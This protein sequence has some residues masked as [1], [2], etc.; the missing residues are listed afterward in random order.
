MQVKKNF[1]LAA[2]LAVCAAGGLM[3]CVDDGDNHVSAQRS[4]YG[5]C[6]TVVYSVAADSV[7]EPLIKESLDSL[8]VTRA[9][10]VE[11]ASYSGSS[12]TQAAVVLCNSQAVA[13][14]KN[15]IKAPTLAGVKSKIYS[16]HEDSLSGLGYRTAEAL[17]VHSFTAIFK[18]YNIDGG[19]LDKPSYT[20]SE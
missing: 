6:D 14:F 7:F 11:K 18:L 20:Y 9:L 4:Y 16:L 15:K 19:V 12:S 8:G 13:T 5:V 17:P 1:K 2:L 10:F 3:S